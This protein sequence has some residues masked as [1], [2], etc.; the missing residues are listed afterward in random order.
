MVGGGWRGDGAA[1]V[2]GEMSLENSRSSVV[3]TSGARSEKGAKS[4]L[5]KAK[6]YQAEH[7]GSMTEALKATAEKTV[8]K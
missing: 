7:G 2:N 5:D 8:K 1:N 3:G 4:H 6:A